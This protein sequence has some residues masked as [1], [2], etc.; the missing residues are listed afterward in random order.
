[1]AFA[2]CHALRPT[3][4]ILAWRHH[5]LGIPWPWPF[6]ATVRVRPA[7]ARDLNGTD[8]DEVGMEKYCPIPFEYGLP[9]IAPSNPLRPTPTKFDIPS[10]NPLIQARHPLPPG[11]SRGALPPSAPV[12]SCQN[13]TTS[14]VCG[15]V[16]QPQLARDATPGPWPHP[17]RRVPVLLRRYAATYTIAY[18]TAPRG[19]LRFARNRPVATQPR[20]VMC[21][22]VQRLA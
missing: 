6:T 14:G 7:P 22:Q 18:P 11:R 1:M 20:L 16:P 4:T 9:T 8:W 5:G 2:S 3:P 15:C 17:R 10:R 13:S 12:Y 21:D 19:L